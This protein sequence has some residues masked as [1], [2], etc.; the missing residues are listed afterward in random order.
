[1]EDE[2]EQLQIL[3]CHFEAHKKKFD[4][5]F[6]SPADTTNNSTQSDLFWKLE[7]ACLEKIRIQR[8]K[9]GAG[10]SESSLQQ[11]YVSI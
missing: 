11:L 5:Y 8:G 3:F 6:I 7:G 1:M 9:G 10:S 4:L 2:N